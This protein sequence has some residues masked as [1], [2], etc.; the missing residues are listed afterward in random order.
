[1]NSEAAYYLF[2]IDRGGQTFIVDSHHT[3]RYA[4]GGRIIFDG[5]ANG[6]FSNENQ[7]TTF[8]ATA[9]IDAVNNSLMRGIDLGKELI[10]AEMRTILQIKTPEATTPEN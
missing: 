9:I 4:D 10:A 8:L 5:S 6:H 1:M 2:S 7:M 3:I